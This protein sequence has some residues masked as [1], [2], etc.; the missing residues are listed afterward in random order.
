MFL[1]FP[2]KAG[3]YRTHGHRLRDTA[4]G[5]LVDLR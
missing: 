3:I 4:L 5:I 2:A 1:V